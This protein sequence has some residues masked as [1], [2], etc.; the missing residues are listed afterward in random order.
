MLICNME[1]I[2][3]YL[4]KKKIQLVYLAY[5]MWPRCLQLDCH[6]GTILGHCVESLNHGASF[7]FRKSKG[8]MVKRAEFL[9]N[10]LLELNIF[11]LYI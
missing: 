1:W 7:T 6:F 3:A 2:C 10:S 4:F 9:F 11:A 8:K 5:I